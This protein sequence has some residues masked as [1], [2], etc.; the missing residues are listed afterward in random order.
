M[1]LP[2]FLQQ[3]PPTVAVDVAPDRVAVSRVERRSGA[4]SLVAFGVEALPAGAVTGA[5]AA[6]NMADVPLVA[7]AIG[8]ALDQAGGRARQVSLVVPDSVARV[9]L[10]R[11]ESVPAKA[12]DLDELI[13]WQV[14]KTTPFPLDEAVVAHTPGAAAAG[15]FEFIVTVA[16][17]DVLQQYE[18]ACELTGA[19]AGIVDLSTFNVVNAVLAQAGAADGGDWLLVHAAPS[20]VSLAVLREGHV[21]FY[22]TRGEEAEGS[23]A[24]LVHQ[25]AM[26]YED[27]L[28]GRQFAR[29]LLLGGSTAAG[30]DELRQELSDRLRIEVAAVDPFRS[31]APSARVDTS[32][33]LADALAPGIGILLRESAVA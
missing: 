8:R 24:D 21:I 11:F 31:A 28:H 13:R 15:A 17:R 7:A 14:R 27:R 5:L 2:S 3:A 12:G 32:A 20:Y 25:T 18:Q 9:S 23:I 30:A 29:A 26:Y 10:V 19:H 16:R 4:P 33:A 1:K 6:P 22:R